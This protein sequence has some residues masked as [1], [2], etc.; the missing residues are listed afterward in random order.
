MFKHL[1]L[2]IFG[3]VLA[4]LGEYLAYYVYTNIQQDTLNGC[5]GVIAFVAIFIGVI[6]VL[7][8]FITL[9]E[10]I[11]KRLE[12]TKPVY[13]NLIHVIGFLFLTVPFF[14]AGKVFYHFTGKYHIE[15]LKQHGIVTKVKIQSEIKGNN[16]RHDLCFDFMHNGKKWEGMLD[17][18]NYQVGDSAVIIYSAENPNEVEWYQLYLEQTSIQVP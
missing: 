2:S 8:P 4:I 12:T 15:Q 5:L 6:M 7:S 3:I 17:H 18:W 11:H 14:V 16:S 9:W 1:I 13:R 10:G